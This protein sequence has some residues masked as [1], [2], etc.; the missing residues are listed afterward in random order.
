MFGVFLSGHEF[1]AIGLHHH[2]TLIGW[3]CII[4]LVV[5]MVVGA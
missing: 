2:V 4:D 5:A 1:L 3:E